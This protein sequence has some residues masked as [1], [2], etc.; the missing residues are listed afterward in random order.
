MIAALFISS[1]S[2]KDDVKVDP[3]GNEPATRKLSR[4][5]QNA[6]NYSVF[7]YNNAGYLNKV[8][9]REDGVDDIMTVTYNTSNK[10]ETAVFHDQKLKF[11]YG[12]GVL[13]KIEFRDENDELMGFETFV[14][15]GTHVTE[16]TF[17]GYDSE[18]N[19]STAV[20][21]FKNEYA[22]DDVK[23]KSVFVYNPATKKL[24]L[25]QTSTLEYDNKNNP[26]AA[27]GVVAQT[28]YQA[29]SVH[30]VTKETV[31]DDRNQLT[32]TNTYT[33]TYDN[34][35]YPTV[36]KEKKVTPENPAGTETQHTFSYK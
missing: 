25:A 10:P 33:Y 36:M 16:S 11:A 22:G 7:E 26:L 14:F 1:C 8:T 18:T 4:L 23:T 35:N 20:L 5:E 9:S 24:E 32:E 17:Y 27:T 29:H 31:K 19:T 30:N 21:A 34:K 12:N 3:I 6:Q 15:K 13:E 2:K 28:L